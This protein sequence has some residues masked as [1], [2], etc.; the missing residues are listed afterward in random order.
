MRRIY[1]DHNATTPLDS[2]VLEVMIA[3]LRR[4][5]GNPSSTHRDGQD[6]RRA[7]D[8]ARRRLSKSLGTPLGTIFFVSGGTEANNLA[9]RGVVGA[10]ERSRRPHLVTSAVEH[11]SVL[12]TCAELAR[13]GAAEVTIV[14]VDSGGRVDPDAIAAALTPR[15]VLISLMLANNEVGTLQPLGEVA[16]LAQ[17]RGVLVHTDAVQALGKV[18]LDLRQLPADLVSLSA[19]KIGGPKG[20]GALVVREHVTLAAQLSGGGQE[21]GRRGG[22]ENVPAIVGFGHALSLAVERREAYVRHVG[23][24]SARLERGILAR[25]AN[26]HIN[27]HTDR[28]PNTLS[29]SFEGLNAGDLVMNLD[30]EGI[31][32]SVGSACAS[33]RV[34]AS[35]VLGAM[36]FS[37]ARAAGTVRFSLGWGNSAEEIDHVLDVLGPLVERLRALGHAGE[38]DRLGR[39][40]V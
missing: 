14:G 34:E 25:I 16:S 6:A 27:G 26:V 35:H 7:I 21:R 4:D 19:H 31:A 12:A 5:L 36:G 13:S 22:T 24:L 17:A 40:A 30:L 3:A 1:L 18:P 15:T 28:L 29:V 20:A 10:S 2:G 33:G 11:P 23:S 38:S 32:C 39:R 8:E 9:L 37:G